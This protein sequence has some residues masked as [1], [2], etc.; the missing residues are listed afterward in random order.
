MLA[1][2]EPEGVA[3]NDGGGVGAESCT[4]ELRRQQGDESEY[5]RLGQSTLEDGLYEVVMRQQLENLYT[6]KVR[7]NDE[8]R[9]AACVSCPVLPGAILKDSEKHLHM[10]HR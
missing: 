2:W 6:M 9:K 3:A 10:C 8:G 5:T 4:V 1:V 7:S